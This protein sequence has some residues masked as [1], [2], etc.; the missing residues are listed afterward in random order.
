MER[1][2]Q[3]VSDD[4]PSGLEI[5]AR[6]RREGWREDIMGIVMK[7]GDGELVQV[8][9]PNGQ[10]IETQMPNNDAND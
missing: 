8:V 4:N 9:W 10:R 7:S 3:A 5:I 6:L 1:E 2:R